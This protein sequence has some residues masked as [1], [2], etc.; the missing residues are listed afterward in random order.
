MF[1]RLLNKIMLICHYSSDKHD[2]NRQVH[3]S[4]VRVKILDHIFLR[5]NKT[6]RLPSIRSCTYETHRI[7]RE[8]K[9]VTPSFTVGKPWWKQPEWLW[10]SNRRTV[11]SGGLYSANGSSAFIE[12]S[13]QSCN[14]EHYGLCRRHMGSRK[15]GH[16]LQNMERCLNWTKRCGFHAHTLY[17]N[18]IQRKR[19][20]SREG[21]LFKVVRKRASW[22]GWMVGVATCLVLCR[23]IRTCVDMTLH[24]CDQGRFR[25]KRINFSE[26]T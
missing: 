1:L 26:G 18:E 22:I 12:K 21:N 5:L 16:W 8:H 19:N 14:F 25:E 15:S 20:S 3:H 4:C 11:G 6:W 13:R 7:T 2:V 24:T 17:F 23:C 9:F 10:R